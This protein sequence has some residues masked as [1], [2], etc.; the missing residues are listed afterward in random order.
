MSR[1]RIFYFISILFIGIS[2]AGFS[3]GLYL[4]RKG[5]TKEEVQSTETKELEPTEKLQK[6]NLIQNHFLN[7]TKLVIKSINVNA[8]IVE[9]GVN[10][11]GQMETPTNFNEIG[12]LKSS[13]KMGENSNLVLAGH[14]DKTT[15]APAVFYNL[16]KLKEGEEILVESTLPSGLVTTK[17]FVVKSVLYVDPSNT[18]HVKLAFEKTNLPTLT[19]ITCGGVWDAK[20]H[21][22]TKRVMVKGALE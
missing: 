22:Y 6:L 3:A 20:A 18:E 8:K 13:A 5:Q 2:V 11:G 17:K 15:G 16:A 4:E 7:P 21:E 10:D 12:W 1:K 19:L 9:V 14:F